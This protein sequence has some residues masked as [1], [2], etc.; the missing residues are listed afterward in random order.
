M[1]GR[2][3]SLRLKKIKAEMLALKQA[4]KYGL[5]RADFPE[6]VL[7]HTFTS[8]GDFGARIT[9]DFGNTTQVPFI[10]IYTKY[11]W[12]SMPTGSYTFSD[13]VYTADFTITVYPEDLDYTYE[14]E[15]IATAPI[16]NATLEIL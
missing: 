10:Q 5:G 14:L 3:F 4:Y 11:S 16:N 2:D 13:G 1:D 9:I 15:V 6:V 12:E 7:S 8:A